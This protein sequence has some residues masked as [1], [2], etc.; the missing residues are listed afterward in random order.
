MGR[1]E[2]RRQYQS[3]I[4]YQIETNEPKTSKIYYEKLLN[5]GYHEERI[6]QLMAYVLETYTKV[7]IGSNQPFSEIQWKTYLNDVRY[8][9][10]NE[11]AEIFDERDAR[12]NIKRIKKEFGDLKKQEQHF[13]DELISIEESLYMAYLFFDVNE[14]EAKKVIHVVIQTLFDEIDGEK[15]NFEE[16]VEEDLCFLAKNILYCSDP[17]LNPA[18]KEYMNQFIEI[19]PENNKT[20]F[21]LPLLCLNRILEKIEQSKKNKG[22]FNI[23]KTYIEVGLSEEPQWFYNENTFKKQ[24]KLF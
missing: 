1:T 19:K 9:L 3:I 12:S 4:R 16:Y 18:L 22:Y 8:E 17:Y 13:L 14:S 6:I 15:H 21:K 2:Q 5:E 24:K 7:M 20:L 10:P 23:I 11:E